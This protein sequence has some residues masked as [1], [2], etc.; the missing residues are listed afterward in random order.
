MSGKDSLQNVIDSY[1]KAAKDDA[2]ADMGTGRC[3]GSCRDHYLDFLVCRT[4]RPVL[5]LTQTPTVTATFT[6]NA[7]HTHCHIYTNLNGYRNTKF[8]TPYV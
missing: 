4:N 8:I 6:L 2:H 7:C 1:K 3:P 5:F